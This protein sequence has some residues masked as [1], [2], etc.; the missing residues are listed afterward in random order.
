MTSPIEQRPAFVPAGTYGL[1]I[2]GEERPANETFDA[3]D[4]SVGQIWTAIPQGST[5]DV[6][7]A[8]AAASRAFH[9][10]RR[11]VPSARQE[12]LA[13]LADAIEADAQRWARLL[14]TENGRPIRE[15]RDGDIPTATGILRYFSGMARGVHGEQIPTDTP[16]SLVYTTREPLGVIA[17]L[18]PW[19]SPLITVAN[20]VAPALATGNTVVL[21]PSEFASASVLEFARIA[22]GILPPG[23]VNVVTG[24]GP[25]VGAALVAHPD[26]AKVT[27]TGGTQTAR[28]I[29]TAAGQALTPAMME[30]G[31]KGAMIVCE[32]A[33]LDTAATDAVSGIYSSN[34]QICVA[35]SRLLV[36]RSVH[37]DFAERF[38]AIAR[39]I[40]VGDAVDPS[41]QF[42][43][44]V[45]ARQR[46]RVRAGLTRAVS[47]GARVVFGANIPELGGRLDE[48]YFLAPTLLADPRGATSA[49]REEFFGPVT[50][51]ERFDTED[52]A[53]ARANE[54]RY[55]LACGVWTRDLARAH[56]IANGL[57]AGIVWVNKW[58]DLAVGVPM[59]GVRDSGFGR[60]VHAETLLEYSAPKVVNIGLSTERPVRWGG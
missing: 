16:D 35:A 42:G 46:D 49:S 44:L 52:E 27:F 19:N 32:D 58:L 22:Q 3:V 59:G 55:G 1:H 26:V 6:D 60:E 24:F 40:R 14:A 30:L 37:D 38:A 5:E 41:T 23:V 47:E 57:D 8:V 7:R 28:A 29:M 2:D 20:K 43:P 11:T 15:G 34:G 12:L 31:G 25:Q 4:P 18:I 54:T 36:H 17:A 39:D 21:K 45:S 53:L 51:L 13:R 48:G 10:W 56:R 33:D 9:S 50:V